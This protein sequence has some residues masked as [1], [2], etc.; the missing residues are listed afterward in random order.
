MA[1]K[2]GLSSYQLSKIRKNLRAFYKSATEDQIASG[3]NW[4][5]DANRWCHKMSVQYGFDHEQVAQVLSA[6]SPRNKWNRNKF[7]AEQVLKAV[8]SGKG[9]SDIKVCT[10]TSNKIKAFNI[11]EGKLD[12][13]IDSPKTYSFVKNIAKLDQEF[14]TVDVWHLRACFNQMIN[15]KSLTA[16]RYKQIERVTKQEAAKVGL[17][18]FEY[19][20]IV[21]ETIRESSDNF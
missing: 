20:A 6:L 21:W 5:Q 7:D 13:T 10:F 19:Q 1:T 9:P 11:L 12:I 18:G 2:K 16:Y 4:Y 8:R 3:L 17:R 14:I 15:P